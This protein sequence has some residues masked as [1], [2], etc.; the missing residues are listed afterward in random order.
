MWRIKTRV[1]N[2]V[3]GSIFHGERNTDFFTN[4]IVIGTERQRD[5]QANRHTARHTVRQADRQTD[6]QID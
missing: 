3:D 4:R 6:F 2:T 5:R 1:T